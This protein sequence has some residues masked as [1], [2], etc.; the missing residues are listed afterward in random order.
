M[1][2]LW[3]FL[4][5]CPDFLKSGQSEDLPSLFFFSGPGPG[6]TYGLTRTASETHRV[7]RSVLSHCLALSGIRESQ[8]AVGPVC[9]MNEAGVRAEG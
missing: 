5:A 7:E 6:Y 8:G 2:E 3:L 9:R 4:Q 1:H